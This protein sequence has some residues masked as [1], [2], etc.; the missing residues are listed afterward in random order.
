LP[1]LLGAGAHRDGFHEFA[2]DGSI[3]TEQVADAVVEGLRDDRF[4][5]LPH[6]EV[7]DY[8]I[9]KATDYERWLGAMRKLQRNLGAGPGG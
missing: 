7:A 5:I 8:F 2:V 1:A 3:T 6:S 4:L 9:D